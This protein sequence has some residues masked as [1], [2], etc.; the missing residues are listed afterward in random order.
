M[1]GCCKDRNKTPGSK[2]CQELRDQLKI[3]LAC[4]NFT[5]FEIRTP[6]QSNTGT[7]EIA[8]HPSHPTTHQ[9]TLADRLPQFRRRRLSC[10]SP[11]FYGISQSYKNTPT[12][13]TFQNPKI[14]HSIVRYKR[15]R[16]VCAMEVS[17]TG[18]YNCLTCTV[19]C[20][21]VRITSED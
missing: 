17:T 11:A 12:N 10:I 13:I 3:N 4:T 1:T 2:N 15:H 7:V 14:D 21:R 6:F 9:A 19:K 18:W 8:P 16:C 5:G 20:L